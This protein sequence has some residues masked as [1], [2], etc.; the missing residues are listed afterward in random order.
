MRWLQSTAVSYFM[1]VSHQSQKYE[2]KRL[3]ELRQSLIT[4]NFTCVYSDD[5][6]KDQIAMLA[7]QLKIIE[8]AKSEIML[9]ENKHED[10]AADM[11]SKF[12]DWNK[13]YL[14]ASLE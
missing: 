12:Q 14:G 10:I 7:N 9:E 1:G 4:K 13:M 8:D 3:K 2:I 5:V 11:H 6:F